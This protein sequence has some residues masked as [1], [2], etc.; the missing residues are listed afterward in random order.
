M[1]VFMIFGIAIVLLISFLF[2]APLFSAIGFINDLLGN[3][4]LNYGVSAIIVFF[5]AKKAGLLEFKR[6]RKR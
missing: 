6:G 5:L 3:P 4:L 2:I 1:V